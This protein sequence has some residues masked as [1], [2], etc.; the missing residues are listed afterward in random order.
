MPRL[1]SLPAPAQ[2]LACGAGGDEVRQAHRLH[3][4]DVPLLVCRL[5]QALVLQPPVVVGVPIEARGAAGRGGRQ[6]SRQ[7]SARDRGWSE[8]EWQGQGGGRR[9]WVAA[10]PACPDHALRHQRPRSER[11]TQRGRCRPQS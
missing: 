6:G 4:P 8:W 3:D 9:A 2:P 10:P 11:R 7:R 1:P 5:A